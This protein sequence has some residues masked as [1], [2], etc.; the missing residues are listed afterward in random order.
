MLIHDLVGADP[1]WRTRILATDLSPAMLE[2]TKQ[3]IYSQFEVNRGLPAN[4][5]IRHFRKQGLQWQIEESLRRMVETRVVNLDQE[6]VNIARMDIVFMRNVLIYF[7]A[8]HEA[9]D[10][11]TGA[12]GHAAR[13]LSHPRRCRD[14]PQP[15][16]LVRSSPD[17]PSTGVPVARREGLS[18]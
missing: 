13:R 11:G 3:G 4:M 15:R 9:S 1:T 5:L 17:R 2:R 18:P 16:R 8:G 7:D 6:F 14:H 10:P 12:S